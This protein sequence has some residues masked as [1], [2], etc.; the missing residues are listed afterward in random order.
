MSDPERGREAEGEDLERQADRPAER[1]L[2]G[3]TADLR[4]DRAQDEPAGADH[5]DRLVTQVAGQLPGLHPSHQ[6]ED[7]RPD[8][9][10]RD[11][12]GE[13][14]VTASITLDCSSSESPAK[15]GSR[16]RPSAAASV[17]GSGPQSGS[18]R[19]PMAER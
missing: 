3:P 15:S 13:N 16:T 7:Q 19:R 6:P 2:P 11:R 10:D 5:E 14:S 8:G 1:Q 4:S 17:T 12:Y 9:D 18:R